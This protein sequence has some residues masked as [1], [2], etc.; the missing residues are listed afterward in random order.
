VAAGGLVLPDGHR[1]Q[2][3]GQDV[4]FSEADLV[5]GWPMSVIGLAGT[6][7]ALVSDGG[8]QDNALRLVDLSALA[9]GTNAVAAYVPFH[10]PT[11]LFWGMAWLP[12]GRALASG[13]GD[14]KVYAFDVDTAAGTLVRAMTSD[15]DA[16]LGDDGSPYY[17]GPLATTPDGSKL[18]IGP[19]AHASEVLVFSL[20]AADYGK[21]LASI[22]VGSTTIFDLQHDPFDA[23]GN[24]FYA[25]DTSGGQLLEIDLSTS[26]VTRTASIPKN[27]EQIVLLD[28][29]WAL[30]TESDSDA[31]AVVNRATSTVATEV[32]V[33]AQGAPHG[34]APSGIA[35]S[36]T[37]NQLY[38]TLG[39]INAIEVIDVTPGTPTTPPALAPSG[40]IPTAWWP[41]GVMVASDGALVVTSGKGHGTGTDD[42]QYTWGNGVITQRMHGGIQRVPPATIADLANQTAIAD[43]GHQLSGLAGHAA[44]TCPAGVSDFPVPTTNTSGP[45]AQIKHVFLVVRENKTYDGVFGDRA[46]LGNGDAALIM[47]S[48]TALQASIWPNARAIAQAFTNFDNFYTDAEQSIQGHT[49]TVYGRTTDFMERSWLSIWGRATRPVATDALPIDGPLEGGVFQ[50]L[51]GAGVSVQDMGEIVGGYT[52]D[53]HYPG[54]FYTAGTPDTD[55]SCYAAGRIRLTCDTSSFTYL[56]QPND[57]TY[58]GAASEPSPEVMIA[59]ND[60]ASG[61]LLDALTHS[62]LWQE[63]LFIVTEDDPQD[64]GDHVDLHRSVLMMASPWIRRGYVSHGHYDMASVYKLVAHVF[65]V[66]YHNDMIANAMAPF[67]AFTSTPDYTPYTYTQRKVT[68]PCNA[69]TGPHARAA[70]KW[71]WEDLDDQPGLSQEI[72]AMMREPPEARGVRIV[73]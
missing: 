41:S 10:E 2:P 24:V 32:P 14:G 47:A 11:S 25:T 67:D 59:V 66:P 30:V 15:I 39:G 29:T 6:H 28:A 21:Q 50:W 37:A 9:A 35:W 7:F 43:A 55:K 63:S 26:K 42:K 65:G 12:P 17:I 62:P 13:G 33:F 36:A 5:G 4:V 22:P 64:G 70:E 19:S 49:W 38:V 8:I 40:R 34:Q 73:R 58:G 69:A 44:I 20:G 48:S 27:P 3:A 51:S 57:H 45:S 46:D 31:I 53:G 72:M 68:A 61:L 1:I 18:V 56:V 52:L 23:S 16:G 60:E 71:D 54:L